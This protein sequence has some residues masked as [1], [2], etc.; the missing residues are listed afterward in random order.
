MDCDDDVGYLS[1]I[2]SCGGNSPL[3]MLFLAEAERFPGNLVQVSD[4]ELGHFHVH[5]HHLATFFY[6]KKFCDENE[7]I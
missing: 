1:G 2:L 6:R 4:L 5:R 3:T 7:I